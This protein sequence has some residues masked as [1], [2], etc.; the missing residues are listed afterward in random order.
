MRSSLFNARWAD[1]LHENLLVKRCH[2]VVKVFNFQRVFTK[3]T[4][5]LLQV[6]TGPEKVENYRFWWL[7]QR[8]A[9]EHSQ[10]LIY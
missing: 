9:G 8:E 2:H 5:K 7:W 4:F 10:Q 1:Q 6:N 3:S